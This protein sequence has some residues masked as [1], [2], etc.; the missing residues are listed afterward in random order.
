MG[1]ARVRV[2]EIDGPDARHAVHSAVYLHKT[3]RILDF[4]CSLLC[5]ESARIQ[6]S[7]RAPWQLSIVHVLTNSIDTH[8]PPS[9]DALYYALLWMVVFHT[10]SIWT[11]KREK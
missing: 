1:E 5:P 6:S 11:T 9:A 7:Q 4:C 8:D 2:I 3:V 10:I